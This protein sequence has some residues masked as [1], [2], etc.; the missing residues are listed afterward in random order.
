M[1]QQQVGRI[2]Q[3]AARPATQPAVAPQVLE[4]PQPGWWSRA[5]AVAGGI[6]GAVC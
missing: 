1:A 6:T 4:E 2:E 5:G 3:P